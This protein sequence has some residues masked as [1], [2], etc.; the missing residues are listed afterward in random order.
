MTPPV[1]TMFAALLVIA[2]LGRRRRQ[3]RRASELSPVDRALIIGDALSRARSRGVGATAVPA[4]AVARGRALH[5]SSGQAP[6]RV[7]GGAW[8]GG[9]DGRP[10]SRR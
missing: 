2:V 5:P 6:Q 4:T 3:R 8:P 7:T 1:F 10:F 9:D